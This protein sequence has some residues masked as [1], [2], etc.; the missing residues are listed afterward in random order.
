MNKHLYYFWLG[1]ANKKFW[2]MVLYF[3]YVW[4]PIYFLFPV[5][6]GAIWYGVPAIFFIIY[7]IHYCG[8]I[9]AERKKD[10]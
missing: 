8:K 9:R 1:I 2:F 5:D 7:L 4:A 3:L 6:I 10:E